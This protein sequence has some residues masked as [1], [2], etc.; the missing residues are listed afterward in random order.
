[1]TE[2]VEITQLYIMSDGNACISW[3]REDAAC[4]LDEYLWVVGFL[5]AVQTSDSNFSNGIIN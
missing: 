1:M 4:H 2:I 5:F 3:V